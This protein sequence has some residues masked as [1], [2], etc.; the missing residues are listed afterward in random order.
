MSSAYLLSLCKAARAVCC[1]E[2]T[3]HGLA[4]GFPL[5]ERTFLNLTQYLA[6]QTS[7]FSRISHTHT[8]IIVI[9]VRFTHLQCQTEVYRWQNTKINDVQMNATHET[10]KLQSGWLDLHSFW[11]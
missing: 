9:F 10:D 7:Y 1:L 6:T 2:T 4:Q 5:L 8:H 3:D 11:E